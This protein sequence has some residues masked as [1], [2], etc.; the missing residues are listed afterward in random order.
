MSRPPAMRPAA[1]ALALAGAAAVLSGCAL[2]PRYHAPALP[3][4]GQGHFVS[5]EPSVYSPQAPPPN[6]WRLYQDPVLDRLVQQAL[7]ENLDLRA[8]AAN[9]SR[10]RGAL[11]QARAGLFPSTDLSLSGIYGKSTT[12]NLIESLNG[13]PAKPSWFY[14]GGL[15]VSY[16][17]DL[18]GR[19]RRTIEAARANAQSVAAAEDLVRVSV[20][21]ETA[22]AY[23]DACAFAESVDVAKRSADLTQ[24]LYDLTVR[25]RDLG[26]RSDFDVASAAAVLDEARAEIPTLEG[27]QRTALFELAVLTGRPPEEISA[28]AAACHTP[29]SMSQLMPVGDGGAMIRRRPDVR[30]AERLLAA[31][32]AQIGVA[33]ADLFPQV[34]L[35]A[36]AAQGGSSFSQLTASKA[37]SWGMGP[38]ITWTFPN[39][40]SAK[41]EVSQARAQAS[42]D[43]ARFDSV[44]LGAL[45]ETEEA[46]TTYASELRRNGALRAARDDNARAFELAQVQLQNGAIGFPDLIQ[47]ERN[48]VQAESALA[49]SDQLLVSDQVSVFKSLGG[50]WEEAPPVVAPK[51]R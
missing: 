48:L 31:D 23:A 4:S 46:L 41:A 9:L 20:A 7:T 29:P 10:A 40:L 51:V 6:W 30:E 15:D 21:A 38:L 45:K 32:T 2:G 17:V 11:E 18:F 47:D 26:A 34:F 24:Q 19:I 44:M 43:I 50:G 12:Q 8:A 42:G 14:D 49:S 3:P 5:A 37:F 35:T 28:E 39:I 13:D 1:R 33:E 22:R 36:N 25:G 16:E 27:E